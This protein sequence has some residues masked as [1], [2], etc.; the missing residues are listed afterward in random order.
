MSELLPDLRYA[1]RTFHAR[2][3]WMIVIVLTLAMDVRIWYTACPWRQP[4]EHSLDG[5]LTG[6]A[7][8]VCG[9][10]SWVRIIARSHANDWHPSCSSYN[11]RSTGVLL[12]TIG[13]DDCRAGCNSAPRLSS[14]VRT[15]VED[16]PEPIMQ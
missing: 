15:T 1:F 8:C 2:P 5:Q 13:A 3:V 4:A 7:T 9:V 12:G 11:Q 10:D 16:P 14:D 6:A